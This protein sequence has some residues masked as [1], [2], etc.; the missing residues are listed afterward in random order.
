MPP[1]SP[2]S[3]NFSVVL[4]YNN[5]EATI[6]CFHTNTNSTITIVTFSLLDFWTSR[7]MDHIELLV[8]VE[9]LSSLHFSR[10]LLIFLFTVGS[11]LPVSIVGQARATCGIASYAHLYWR[12][13]C[14]RRRCQNLCHS[15]DQSSKQHST[16]TTTTCA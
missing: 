5:Y 7:G 14:F 10:F 8:C 16:T 13:R 6:Q 15:F 4:P 11:P 3:D 12:S 2:P 9:T 1:P